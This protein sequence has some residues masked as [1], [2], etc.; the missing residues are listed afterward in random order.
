MNTKFAYVLVSQE[1]D[2]YY[3]MFLLSHYSLRFHHPK[4]T[5]EIVLVM[6]PPTHSRLVHQNA[7][8]LN[9]V[10][11]IV[12]DV[13]AKYS[14]LQ[15]SRYIKTSLRKILYGAFLYLDTDTIICDTLDD[16]DFFDGD[17]CAVADNHSGD[18]LELQVEATPK[19]LDWKYLAGT[20]QYNGGVIYVKDTADAALFFE[21]WHQN[22]EHSASFNINYDQLS[23]RKTNLE[24]G[25]EISEIDGIWNCQMARESSSPFRANAKILHFQGP[26]SCQYDFYNELT[27]LKIRLSG[28]VS[29]NL[30]DMVTS[31]CCK[32]IKRRYLLTQEDY[33]NL[34]P[35]LDTFHDYPRYYSFLVLISATHRRVL[36]SLYRLKQ[37]FSR[38]S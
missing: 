5:A 1:G 38:K 27:F 37:A 26:L 31:P 11:P 36:S 30:A 25:V 20:K 32:S 28:G 21:Q 19:E 12:V 34:S 4:E 14:V 22:W 10:T 29:G 3:E 33:F 17:I 8:V 35:M 7:P 2:Y 23:L 13:P 15:R 24:S 9:D 16:I 6:D 18:I